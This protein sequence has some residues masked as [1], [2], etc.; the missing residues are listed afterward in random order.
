MR[1]DRRRFG[2]A[3]LGLSVYGRHAL[4][5]GVTTL[6]IPIEGQTFDPAFFGIHIHNNGSERNWPDIPVG[7]LRLWDAGVGWSSLERAAG[8]FDFRRLDQYVAWAEARGIEVM[9]P[10][11]V[12]PRWA[13]ARPNEVGAYGPGTA[14]EPERLDDWRIYVRTLAERYR[15]RI[16]AYQVLNEANLTGFFSGSLDALVRLTVAAAEEIRHADPRAWVIAPSGVGVDDRVQ[17]P[18]RLLSAGV[19]AVVDVCAYHLYH[20]GQ[21]PEAIVDPVR[22]L[23]QANASAGYPNMR[24]WNT[25][26]GYMMQN[27][28]AVWSQREM[29]NILTEAAVAAYLPRDLL[30][31]RSLG[32]ERFFWYAWDGNKMGLIDPVSRTHRAPAKAYAQ[33]I[34][35]F[36]GKTIRSCTC[37][38]DGVWRVAMTAPGGAQFE[39]VW[40]DPG[41]RTPVVE[42]PSA[43]FGGVRR[44][45]VLDGVSDWRGPT[46]R[47][48]V[49]GV[50]TMLERQ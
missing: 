45:V 23:L 15:G 31:A 41:A 17:W 34:R 20:E 9:L 19:G 25:E 16:R 10:F 50:V 29:P 48:D 11:G 38:A 12:T 8:R 39:A 32:F 44:S 26:S 13:S 36:T 35:Q 22:R 42:L 37:T 27:P 33:A 24:L 21:P 46:E 43:D 14:A 30:L 18:S 6:R 2:M 1:P 49:S 40:L 3:G 28:A 47:L 7:S 4:G 5:V